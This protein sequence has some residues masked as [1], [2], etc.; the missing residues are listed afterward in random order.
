MAS[1]AK[2]LVASASTTASTASLTFVPE[3]ASVDV[4]TIHGP[5]NEDN[6]ITNKDGKG[7][8]EFSIN[9]LIAFPCHH[10]V[11]IADSYSCKV[12]QC[13]D[14]HKYPVT[15]V[16]FSHGSNLKIASCDTRGTLIVWDVLR[17][18]VSS[19][20]LPST[21]KESKGST[22]IAFEWM[23]QTHH[24]YDD[25]KHCLLILYSS[26]LLALYDVDSSQVLWKKQLMTSAKQC[27]FLPSSLSVDPFN[28]G[29]L[30]LPL[31]PSN[32]S[33]IQCSFLH[34]ENI[35]AGESNNVK[36]S[37]S[38]PQLQQPNIDQSS[39]P[40]MRKY[41]I[42]VTDF[43]QASSLTKSPDLKLGM[44]VLSSGNP[45]AKTADDSS[46]SNIK[47]SKESVSEFKI[48]MKQVTFNKNKKNEVIVASSR[49][50]AF[51]NLEDNCI[52]MTIP[53]ERSSLNVVSVYSCHQRNA[54]FTLHGKA[55]I[56]LFRLFN[57]ASLE[58]KYFKTI[59]QSQPQSTSTT[60]T[61][62]G[63]AV[64][65]LRETRYALLTSS[66]RII[67]HSLTVE[68]TNVQESEVTH[69]CLS[70]LI[71]VS[72]YHEDKTSPKI[73]ITSGDRKLFSLPK[74]TVIKTCPPVTQSNWEQH[75][76]LI[77]VGTFTG[78]VIIIDLKTGNLEVSLQV[79]SCLVRGIEWTSLTSFIS[80]S[81]PREVTRQRGSFVGH[82]NAP[83]VNNELYLTDITTGKSQVLRKDANVDS[84]PIQCIRVS[85]LKQYFV[86][87]FRE[88]PM[89]IWDLKA[90]SLI[91]ILPDK[92]S[93][94][95]CIEWSPLSS[96]SKDF[97]SYGKSQS[98]TTQVKQSFETD[99][100]DKELL[101]LILPPSLSTFS[102]RENF[103]VSDPT[104]DLHH[105]SV[106]GPAVKEV[107]V[108]K[109]DT[110]H[111]PLTC[112]SWKGD[113][114]VLGFYDGNLLFWN[115]KKRSSTNKS[116]QRQPVKKIKFA[117]GKRNPN[118]LVLYNDYLELWSNTTVLTEI[119][120]GFKEGFV[121]T[122]VDAD[123]TGSDRP[124][125][126]TSDS[127]LHVTDMSLVKTSL[128]V[129][130]E[131]RNEVVSFGKSN[132]NLV[133]ESIRSKVIASFLLEPL[134][135]L[136]NK[137]MPQELVSRCISAAVMTGSTFLLDFWTLTQ[138]HL[139]NLDID[140]HFDL[141]LKNETY[142]AIQ[143]EVAHE[144]H[145][146]NKVDRRRK[147]SNICLEYD[148]LLGNY[149]QAVQSLLESDPASKD[150]YKLD[151]MKA[152]LIASLS[153]KKEDNSCNPAEAV[154]K[155]AAASLIATGSIDEGVH[156]LMVTSNSKDA[157]RYLQANGYWEKSIW[158][159]KT[160][161]KQKESREILDKWLS[162]LMMT[163][164]HSKEKE[165]FILLSNQSFDR[166]V[167][168]LIN[169][170]DIPTAALFSLVCDS[171]GLI[172]FKDS[173]STASPLHQ[174]KVNN[175]SKSSFPIPFP[176]PQSM[177]PTEPAGSAFMGVDANAAVDYAYDQYLKML[178][179]FNLAH[180]FPAKNKSNQEEDE[181][182][183][184]DEFSV[185]VT[186]LLDSLQEEETYHENQ[187]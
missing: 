161:L 32:P 12:I 69:S 70:Q 95:S 68:E 118:F 61:I 162:H 119:R 80:Y 8:V 131:R 133:K 1:S 81:Y 185:N 129:F 109:G 3:I 76:P 36:P 85:H 115:L 179:E 137:V 53:L 47:E 155:L 143:R 30:V 138:H 117:P 9:G 127:I 24:P 124:V 110:L 27:A 21:M 49:V 166:V 62:I 122:V 149:D 176:S 35:Y 108:I 105:Y 25:R 186:D 142:Q 5:L 89:E 60:D 180:L 94:A 169:R 171:L 59:A 19:F 18:S 106:E 56:V 87:C 23:K 86:I 146:R 4:R 101:K 111:G 66:G 156:L 45:L 50:I 147:T 90:L 107:S 28:P 116:G 139:L 182:K 33:Q 78:S 128:P 100:K 170:H 140:D 73:K 16:Q 126:L 44:Q 93:S 84:S 178:S 48:E 153:S 2:I 168:L 98:D 102:T 55:G 71:P 97:A 14:R 159:A 167:S 77:A 125:L 43:H 67:M 123:W 63:F 22:I 135:K 96:K 88:R 57:K 39:A 165:V 41:R 13:L 31:T 74:S 51:L 46:D 144:A 145:E 42:F 158:M 38:S 181:K 37:S 113:Q 177:S 34:L 91:K 20:I 6:Y 175:A 154:V 121:S 7:T 72:S 82:A 17:G 136:D 184:K 52:L 163:Q 112:V 151:V 160:A 132:L 10:L 130:L 114:I 99:V 172:P 65:P 148:L 187:K 58:N 174:P 79:H 40:S 103:I 157:C 134:Q 173:S 92:F 75:R 141:F 64:D 11:M 183:D 15:R 164:T 152:C 120:F 104:G 54:I 150:E 29:S 26:S 83:T